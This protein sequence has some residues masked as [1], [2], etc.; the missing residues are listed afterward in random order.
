MRAWLCS[1]SRLVWVNEFA[2]NS[3]RDAVNSAM[4]KMVERFGF[5]TDRGLRREINEDSLL[6]RAPIFAVADGMGG[7]EAGEIAS[8]ACLE[9]LNQDPIFA[10]GTRNATEATVRAA[11]QRADAD[12]VE[13]TKARGGTTVTGVVLVEHG[14][15]P[16]MLVFN[17]GDSRVYQLVD[18]VLAQIT[19][20]HSEVQELLTGGY[21]NAEEASTYP[22]RHVITR[23]LGAGV[24]AKA[25][26]W[27]LPLAPEQRMLICTDGLT[28]ELS[29]QQLRQT[30]I[31]MADPQEAVE[32]LIAQANSSGG[33]DNITA[34]VVD[35]GQAADAARTQVL[36]LLDTTDAVSECPD[37]PTHEENDG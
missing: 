5:G 3:E 4:P 26:V 20:D 37:A 2:F 23:A 6:V 22:R 28:G 15:S 19:V 34:I 33:H 24:R 11:L 17:I 29:N 12:V 8:Q 9:S 30:L 18:G 36:P 25:D 32:S 10:A 16:H 1:H 35:V 13:L 21:L 31:A 14:G 7:H 27:L